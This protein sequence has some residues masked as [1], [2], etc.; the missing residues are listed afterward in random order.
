MRR[1]YLSRLLSVLMLLTL[2]SM[3]VSAQSTVKITIVSTNSTIAKAFSTIKVQT[4]LTVFYNNQLINDQEQIKL[5]FVQ[6]NLSD[7]M[8][9]ILKS[10]GLSWSIKEKFIILEKTKSATN[11]VGSLMNDKVIVKGIVTDDMG[12]PL[13]GVSVV[14]KG[15]LLGTTTD[16]NGKYTI[17]IS[18][19]SE[20]LVFS[21][22]GYEQQ[23]VVIG[24]NTSLNVKLK[25][26][27]SVLNQVVII[28]YG[29]VK[30]GDLTGSVASLKADDIVKNVDLS[31]NEAIQGRISGVQVTSTDGAPGAAVS[32]S[33]RG[34]SSISASNEPLYV[35]DGFAQFGG[36]NLNINPGDIA[37]IEVLKDASATAIYGSRGANG[38]VIITTKAGQEGKFAINYDS[39]VSQQQIVKKLSV[40][41]AQQYAQTQHFLLSNPAGSGTD[42]LYANWQTYQD[43]ASVDWQDLVYRKAVMQNHNLSFSGGSKDFKLS[44]SIAYTSQD[45]IAIGTSFDRVTGRINA[46]TNIS[47]Y[48]TNGT[49]L[50]LSN[51]NTNGPSLNGETGIA[52]AILQARPI[53]PNSNLDNLLNQSLIG[54]QGTNNV[55]NPVIEL[56]SPRLNYGDFNANFNTYLQFALV[57]GLIFKVSLSAKYEQNINSQF[58]PSNTAQG[59][60]LNGLANII[61]NNITDWLNEN[62]LNYTNK[63]NKDNTFSLLAGFT[64]QNDVTNSLTE[65]ASNFSIQSLGYSN[66]ALG[67]GYIA[68]TSNYINQGLESLL[69]RVNYTYKGRYLFTASVRSDGSSKFQNQKWSTFPSGA[70][71]WR[72]TDEPFMKKIDAVSSLKLRTSWGMTGNQSIAPYSTFTK[73][74]AYNPIINEQLAV[75]VAPLQL[76]NQNLK[77]ETTVQTDIGI[78]LGL[79]KDRVLLTVDGYYKKSR[80]L[81]LNSP[82]SLYSG[83]TTVF[84]NV[85]E[86]EVKGLEFNLATVNLQGPLQWNSSFNIA[87]NRSKVLSLNDNQTFFATGILGRRV[88]GQ[89][90]V[91]VGDPLGEIY[92]YQYNG[93]FR[94]QEALVNGAQISGSSAIGSRSY[95]DLSG[96]S[97][98]PDGKIDQ[99]DL[100][101]IGNGNP[102]FFGGL[103]NDFK[104][105]S[106]DL[107]ALF[108]Y[109]YGNHILNSLKSVLSRPQSYRSGLSTIMDSWTPQNTGGS[110]AKW[111]TTNTEYDINSSYQVEDGSFIR[112]KTVIIGYTVPSSLLKKIA[113]KGLRI[114]ASGTNLWTLTPYSGYDPEVSYFNSIVTPGADLGA[115][116]RAKVYTL[117]I[118]LSL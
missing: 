58:Y 70:F 98:V 34:G 5:N 100:T 99:N 81:L 117:G 35:I 108:T 23:E 50:Y 107:S 65:G 91:Q 14:L 61:T 29:S 118:N 40:L 8:D 53:V 36:S 28:G 88:V 26:K 20:T 110:E 41:N 2:C 69:G 37:S 13:I 42:Q 83:Y 109:S 92:G 18:N 27:P 46:I 111:G 60:N 96:P 112:L 113:V 33:V 104:Y 16:V 44:G 51:A 48:I 102:L 74:Q 57:K 86:I 68:P 19:A 73:Y 93:L 116:P 75:G 106:F 78:D 6:A 97:G 71:A 56:T 94:S 25:E 115:Y 95:A 22:I 17:N 72:V 1:F 101:A 11:S 79:F 103:S 59:R 55:N 76:G 114:Y 84:R 87:F 66:L 12:L 7:V 80:D 49:S 77:W 47:K 32:L 90:L 43:S 85:G 4:G 63:I 15:K 38:V 89:Y 9:F 21:Y 10:K 30:R 24:N 64:A 39:Y 45:G 52:Y 67:A 54:D 31:L 62:T 3:A 105:K 82:I